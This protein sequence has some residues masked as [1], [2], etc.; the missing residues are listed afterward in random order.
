[1]QSVR[2]ADGQTSP[3]V[4]SDSF[5]GAARA[6]RGSPG[7]RSARNR[8]RALPRGRCRAARRVVLCWPAPQ[9]TPDMPGKRQLEVLMEAVNQDPATEQLKATLRD[10]LQGAEARF[11]DRLV[12]PEQL[13]EDH[14]RIFFEEDLA[15]SFTEFEKMV[16]KFDGNN[17][18]IRQ[19]KSMRWLQ[20]L[21]AV[22]NTNDQ[23]FE[24]NLRKE[25]GTGLSRRVKLTYQGRSLL[26]GQVEPIPGQN[27]KETHALELS[28]SNV[29]A[30]AALQAWRQRT[31]MIKANGH[32]C[33]RATKERRG[34]NE[35]VFRAG[36]QFLVDECGYPEQKATHSLRGAQR[37]LN[38]ILF[39]TSA[40]NM[41][42]MANPQLGDIND[43]AVRDRVQKRTISHWG[44]ELYH[45]D[46]KAM[47]MRHAV[48]MNR[49]YESGGAANVSP[50]RAAQH[51]PP[52]PRSATKT[53]LSLLR[54]R[55]HTTSTRP[56]QRPYLATS[57]LRRWVALPLPSATQ[58]DHQRSHRSQLWWMVLIIGRWSAC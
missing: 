2:D 11:V 57:K 23:Y 21:D 28:W 19:T 46:A 48:V 56:R 7:V 26:L 31:A 35:S 3:T 38:K 45:I 54:R 13:K 53:A 17:P 43:R 30:Q 33:E 22:D 18:A 36:K 47:R 44:T 34:E 40:T 14:L 1:M 42:C 5:T 6:K 49:Q 27:L 20:T 16:C 4:G 51:V 25:S 15:I 39:G 9:D 41:V 8:R 52:P 10:L 32:N 55:R 50:A 29:A 37:T 12:Q 24:G 58:G